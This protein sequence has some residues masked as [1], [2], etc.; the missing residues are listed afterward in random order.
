MRRRKTF[1][2]TLLLLF[3]LTLSLGSVLTE[4]IVPF[5]EKAY[6]ATTTL[7]TPANMNGWAWQNTG[8][9]TGSFAAGPAQ[10]P[11]GTASARF[12]VGTNGA[13]AVQLR[14]NQLSGVKLSHI[15][16]LMYG[17]YVSQNNGCQAPY[18]LLN[19]DNDNNGTIDDLLFFEPCYQNGTYG[20]V[21]NVT[22]PNQGNLAL[23]TWQT[24]N[25]YTGGWW[26]Q[27]S[28]TGGP[29]LTTLA[30]YSIAHSGATIR[31]AANNVGGLRIVAGFGAGAWNNVIGYS[32]NLTIGV[33][34]NDTTYDFEL[35]SSS[36]QCTPVSNADLQGYWK[37][38]EG[39]GS[40]AADS[41]GNNRTGTLQS[42]LASTGW[43]TDHPST[44]TF[45]DP[46]ALRFDGT[47]DYVQVANSG[48]MN[49][50]NLTLSAW[51]KTDTGSLV[52][53]RQ[54][55][56]R[57]RTTSGEQYALYLNGD[58]LEFWAL[59]LGLSGNFAGTTNRNLQANIWYH[60]A[61]TFDD[62]TNIVR[63][64]V[65][66]TEVANAPAN[67]SFASSNQT[68]YI[69]SQVTN[70]FW[71]G[72]IDDVRVY[73][74]ALIPTEILQLSLGCG[75]TT[76]G[77]SSSMSSVSSAS[78]MS[79]ASSVSSM[80][81]ASSASSASSISSQSSLSSVSSSSSQSSL[82]SSAMAA[83]T[84]NGQTATIFARNGRIVGGPGNGN[85]YNGILNGTSGNDV[86]VG[87]NQNDRISGQSGNDL[88]C[89]G[90]GNDFIDG[91]DGNDTVFGENGSDFLRGGDG[92]DR[93]DGGNGG[94]FMRGDDDSDILCGRNGGDLQVGG[95]ANDKLDGGSGNNFLSGSSGT[96]TCTNASG[97]SSCEV[98][99]A[100]PECSSI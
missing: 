21:P 22:I 13:D 95:A 79:S 58:E 23:N 91:N 33:N 28:Q 53:Y 96:D 32:D 74:R 41:S 17:T 94:D 46:Y 12:S 24:W 9:A 55:L 31:N 49:P 69:G 50:A 7:V 20:T 39:T 100:V 37:F 92:N 48:A 93:L 30:Q 88:I 78:S 77:S 19:I 3:V 43:T 2:G 4:N 25:A 85:V 89:G 62:S 11:A 47:D 14:Q 38:D 59:D 71:K 1:S 97:E 54:I 72:P 6:A 98:H 52:G 63:L 61:A 64:Y 87:T 36:Q 83:P 35:S 42:G 5:P 56:R 90:N 57:S 15:T 99:A 18:I 86:I 70:Y 84:C 65:N 8:T 26:T 10:P 60:V 40:V 27:S 81:S 75:G 80:S 51:V 82:S 76:T 68:L 34:G 16:K 66:G 67:G 44:I 45:A 73:H 29:P